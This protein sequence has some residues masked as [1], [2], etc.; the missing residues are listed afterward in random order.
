MPIR[1]DAA[2]LIAAS[3]RAADLRLYVPFDAEVEA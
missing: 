2:L 1:T 3:K